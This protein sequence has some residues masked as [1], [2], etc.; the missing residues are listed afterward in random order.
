MRG[1][2]PETGTAVKFFHSFS[3]KPWKMSRKALDKTQRETERQGL[4]VG[5]QLDLLESEKERA[6]SHW[7]LRKKAPPTL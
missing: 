4:A 2:Y 3:L 7:L 6:D 5:A 1:I